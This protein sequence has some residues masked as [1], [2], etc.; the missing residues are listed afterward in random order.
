MNML[1]GKTIWWIRFVELCS[2][3]LKPGTIEYLINP[4]DPTH[5]N[6]FRNER[7]MKWIESVEYI[8][9]ETHLL[10]SLSNSLNNLVPLGNKQPLVT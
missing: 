4:T 9:T 10:I 3:P 1:K 8:E 7:G 2:A 6:H 5:L